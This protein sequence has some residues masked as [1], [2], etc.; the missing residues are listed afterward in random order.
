MSEVAVHVGSPPSTDRSARSVRAARTA[1]VFAQVYWRPSTPS[2]HAFE[3]TTVNTRNAGRK[4]RIA[5]RARYAGAAHDE[6][7]REL[8]QRSEEQQRR[9]RA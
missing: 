6:T 8:E 5:E 4:S 2:I 7:R 9:D 1:G 3:Q